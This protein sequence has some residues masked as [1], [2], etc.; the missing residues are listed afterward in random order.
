MATQ[1]RVI[2]KPSHP[3]ASGSTQ[4]ALNLSSRQIHKLLRDIP[5]GENYTGTIAGLVVSISK[6]LSMAT[7]TLPDERQ[8]PAPVSKSRAKLSPLP[9]KRKP[10]RP[11]GSR[12]KAAALQ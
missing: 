6:P 8:T 1:Y 5:A 9:A 2:L 10:G 3:E 7:A 4:Q 11:V 12:N